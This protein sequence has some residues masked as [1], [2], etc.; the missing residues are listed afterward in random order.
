MT[1]KNILLVAGSAALLAN[2]ALGQEAPPPQDP[3]APPQAPVEQPQPPQPANPNAGWRKFGQPQQAGSET[4]N[5]TPPM[6]PQG[7]PPPGYYPPPQ[8]QYPPAQYPPQQGQYPAQQGQY[9][10]QQGQYPRQ[11]QQPNYRAYPPMAPLPA[12]VTLPAGTWVKIHTDRVLSSDHSKKDDVFTG[13]L[14]QPIIVNGYVI[15]RRGQNITGRVLNATK[16]GRVK[17]TSEVTLELN[18]VA[19]ADGQQL[20]LKTALVEYHGPTSHGRDAFAIGSTTVLGA[21]IGGAVNGGVGA[22]VGAAAGLVASTIGVLVTRG[23]PTVIFPE[24]L[25]TFK[26]TEPIAFPTDQ[27]SMA[28]Q[29]AGPQDYAP[30]MQT[31][32]MVGPRPGYGPYYGGPYGYPYPYY[33]GY[34]YFSG[35]Y[36]YPWFGT[37][38]YFRGG[39][40]W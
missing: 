10:P 12:K 14:A 19:I 13:T 27:S 11:G 20:P 37:G 29:P 15:A 8:G 16:A 39:R 26:T 30:A 22:G 31:R 2:F 17:G 4:P 38:I 3:P 1:T 9:P 32:S 7:P 25:L 6:D 40:R 18:E 36:G 33:G 24:S 23:H 28:F 34:P 21:A 35:G 5:T